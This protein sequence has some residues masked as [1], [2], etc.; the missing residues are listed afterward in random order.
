MV[1]EDQQHLLLFDSANDW[2]E[3]EQKVQDSLQQDQQPLQ[4]ANNTPG[5]ITLPVIGMTCMSCVNAITSVLTSSPGIK[6][7]KVSLKQEEAVVEFDPAEIT[8]AQIKEAIED[9]GFDVPFDTDAADAASA[10]AGPLL[11]MTADA[12][13]TAPA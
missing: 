3:F 12:T 11:N 9:C 6:N 13:T 7:V 8:V 1:A 10:A 2:D 4:H 5:T